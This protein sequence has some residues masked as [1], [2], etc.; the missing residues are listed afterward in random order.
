MLSAGRLRSVA[1][2]AVPG[3]IF[4]LHRGNAQHAT[5][6]PAMAI[7]HMAAGFAVAVVSVVVERFIR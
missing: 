7:D 1:W 4:G 3:S 5:I 6:S 2:G